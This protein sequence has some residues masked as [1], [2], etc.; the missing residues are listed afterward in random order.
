MAVTAGFYGPA[1]Q[2]Q[3]S[4]TTAR[5]QDW[6]T[7][8]PIKC[9]LTASGYTVDND[10]H[11]FYNDITNELTT[12][13]GYTAGGVTLGSK[14]LNLVG[15]SNRIELDAGDAQWTSASFTANKAFVY[16]DTAGASTTDPLFS[17]VQF[18]AD[19]TV[20]AGTFTVQW[21]ATGIANITYT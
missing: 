14:A 21:D 9:G 19:N 15:A 6:V 18:G 4:A 20:S 1:I 13:G 8:D 16:F 10:A 12:T 7:G 17:W 3:W 5:R 11:D 2:G